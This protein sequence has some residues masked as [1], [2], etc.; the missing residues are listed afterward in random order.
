MNV[1]KRYK[2]NQLY[3]LTYIIVHLLFQLHNIETI[4]YNS[5]SEKLSNLS[6]CSNP[7]IDNTI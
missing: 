7:T 5:N 6:I 3:T 4:D 1:L 2:V